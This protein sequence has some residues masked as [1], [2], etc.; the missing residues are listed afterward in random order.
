MS[1]ANG[2]TTNT[3]A[4]EAAAPTASAAADSG[5][6]TVVPAAAPATPQPPAPDEHTGK[7][8]LYIRS[9]GKRTLVERTQQPTKATA[10][11]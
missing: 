9:G 2:K 5:A 4:E 8:G 7:G 6:T 10:K 11:E 3:T 1:K